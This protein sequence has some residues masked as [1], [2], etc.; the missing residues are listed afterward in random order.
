[1]TTT[2]ASDLIKKVTSELSDEFL[3]EQL[4]YTQ[5]ITYHP[6]P[7][8]TAAKTE[9]QWRVR[10]DVTFDSHI[11][12]GLDIYSEVVLGRGQESQAFD[13]IFRSFDIEQM[14]LSRR[15][16]A[17][18]PTDEHLYLVDLGSTNG[19]GINGSTIGVNTPYALNH[20]DLIRLGRLEF[21]IYFI[22]QPMNTQ[23]ARK[24]N[25]VFSNLSTIARTISSQLDLDSV[26]KQSMEMA[27]SFIP[28][29]EVSIWLA[30]EQSG[31]LFLEAG[32]GLENEQIQRLPV[33]DTLAGQVMTSGKA[34]RSHRGKDGAQ[35][36][37]KTGY[38]VEAVIYVPLMLAGTPFGVLSAANRERGSIFTDNDERILQVI[39]DVTAVAVH[40]ARQYQVTTRA[41]LRRSKI[42][43]ALNVVL[44]HDMKN[45]VKSTVGYA[46]MLNTYEFSSPD[47]ADIVAEIGH[48]GSSMS[49]LINRLIEVTNL[50]DEPTLSQQ[51][52]DLLETVNSAVEEMR[53]FAQS[54][55][56][57]L[58]LEVMGTPCFIQGDPAMIYRS[59]LNLLDNAIKYIPDEGYVLVH[60]IFNN[61]EIVI[62]VQDTGPGIPEEDLPHLFDQYYRGSSGDNGQPNIG[63]G[64]EY[65]RSTIEAH[66]GHIVV[67]NAE[68]GG[69]EFILSL[70][71]RL[72]VV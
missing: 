20:G 40:N 4:N 53:P 59:M 55:A 7:K 13:A 38:L 41:S 26:L 43:T 57:Q 16:A 10:L 49:H 31:E 67:R 36:K 51:P 52:F 14:G 56:V 6:V 46:G 68:G 64:L 34:V 2:A 21:T 1:M 3:R 32:R 71:G 70:P 62:R 18:R 33:V 72:R 69:A 23:P 66:R 27:M 15:H 9:A 29:D 37:I 65:V 22:K 8:G 12:V 54:K 48:N 39:A 47:M 25:D 63:L 28:T 45:M 19:S 58:N 30:D 24:Q 44:A 50:N 61:H 42:V 17:I 60:T 5:D 35:V 11:Q